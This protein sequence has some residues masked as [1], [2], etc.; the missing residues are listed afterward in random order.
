MKS[1][2]ITI[3]IVIVLLGLVSYLF[4]G[5]RLYKDDSEKSVVKNSLATERL[6]V[7][8]QEA[9]DKVI[10]ETVTL[11]QGGFVVIR[12]SDG[13]RLGQVIEMSLYLEPGEHRKINIA[14]GD[15]Y[16]YNEVDQLVAM[17]YDDNGDKIFSEL[18]EPSVSNTAVFVKTGE[19]VPVSVLKQVA[20]NDGMGME[21][22]RYSDTGFQP[23][24]L[25]V[26]VG[27]MVEFINQ[28]DKQMWVASNVHPSHEI[29]PTF[30]Q[31]KGIENGKSYMYVF[32]KKGTWGYHDHINPEKEGV[33]MVE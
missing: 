19:S 18:D 7:K 30:D 3:F 10:I 14:L 29:L 5:D 16:T 15:F 25:T 33:V 24:K 6:V 17:I 21:T 13:Q 1:K 27:T 32:D 28:S 4:F 8:P 2:S 26:P 12:G 23:A 20:A 9:R 11:N 22:V 31:F